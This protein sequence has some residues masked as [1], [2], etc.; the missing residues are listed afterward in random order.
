MRKLILALLVAASLTLPG[1]VAAKDIVIGFT[2]SET[3]RLN[4]D[5]IPQMHGFELWQKQVNSNGGIQVGDQHYKVRFAHYD[6][7]SK[8]NRVQQL[9]ARLVTDDGADFLFSPYSSGLTATAAV[10][11][12]QYGKP[13]I[14]TGAAE[15]KTYTLGNR[16][17][18]QL[19]TP[20]DQYLAS[21]L[22]A[23][24]QKDPNAKVAL[25]YSNDGFSTAAAQ[26]AKDHAKKLGLNVV[27]DEAYDPST[28]DFSSILNKV[29]SSGAD[30]LIG[31]GH[32][33]DGST[34][35]RQLQEQDLNLKMITLLVAPDTQ[36]FA[37]LGDAAYGVSVP[38]QWEPAA[39]FKP[40]FGPTS[41]AFTKAYQQAY[42]ATPGYHAAGGYAAGLVLQHAIEQA[43]SI[44]AD[45]VV[46]AL[47]D[48]D[49]T[50][51]YGHVKFAS[52]QSRHGLQVGHS[53]VL[54][55]WQ[56]DSSG[57]LTKEVVWPGSAQ[58]APL[59]YPI[60]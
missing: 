12:E 58:T 20:A 30:V 45:K 26:G 46:A 40:D 29:V 34:L 53:M 57:K 10:I 18:F 3:G 31:G 49:A 23:V 55:Q 56:K 4:A 6:D 51:F 44:D 42:D 1:V 13:M 54:A 9:Y 47:N 25:V 27:L 37:D 19:Y 8:S 16:Y 36:K 41:E 28:S 7:Q 24:K 59:L 22:D 50:I 17:L 48:M 60:K 11:S 14:T 33:A 43:G 39:A 15:G 38:S 35:A 2:A 5:S 32:F 21:S 52:E